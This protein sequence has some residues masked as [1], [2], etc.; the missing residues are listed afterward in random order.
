MRGVGRVSAERDRCEYL[1][2]EN[3]TRTPAFP[4]FRK[5]LPV[6][7]EP[8]KPFIDFSGGRYR[9]MSSVSGLVKLVRLPVF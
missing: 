5:S 7:G 4:S 3:P 1:Q 6:I 2:H 8:V 9:E